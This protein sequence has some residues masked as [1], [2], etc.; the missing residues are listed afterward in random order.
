M[1]P[2]FLDLLVT[3]R[4]NGFIKIWVYCKLTHTD[5]YFTWDSNNHLEHKR[6]ASRTI[7]KRADR[8]VTE[9]EDQMEKG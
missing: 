6:L 4:D 3:D 5:Q 9:T 2:P 7:L 8:L 1:A